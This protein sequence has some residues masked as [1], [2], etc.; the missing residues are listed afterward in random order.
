MVA[1]V[2]VVVGSSLQASQFTW[3][4]GLV[5]FISVGAVIGLSWFAIR[6]PTLK[7]GPTE[8]K[9]VD[10][11]GSPQRMLRSDLAFIFRGQMLRAVRGGSFW[12]KSYVFASSDGTVRMWP[13]AFQF[14]DKGV[15]EFAQRLDVALRGDFSVQVK[16]RVDPA[17]T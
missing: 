13:W 14:T 6:L 2:V 3:T 1:A 9:V 16:D 11:W 8:V 4:M 17:A 15:A 5:L 7:A 10:P 12:D